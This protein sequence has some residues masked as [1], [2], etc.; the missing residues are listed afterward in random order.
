[1]CQCTA[2]ADADADVAGS[3]DAVAGVKDARADNLQLA[4]TAETDYYNPRP[5]LAH[6]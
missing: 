6:A 4:D 2:S 5:S 1:M 3:T